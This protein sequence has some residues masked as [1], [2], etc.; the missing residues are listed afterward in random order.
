MR[1][2]APNEH[3]SGTGPGG[4]VFTDGVAELDPKRPEHRA[5][6]AYFKDRGYG[7]DGDEATQPEGAPVQP[8]SREVGGEHAVGERLRDAAV[9]PRESDFLVPTNAGEA[10]P[11]GPLVVAPGVHASETGPIHPGDVHVD[12]PQVQEAQET[13]L[14]EAVFVEGKDVTEATRAAAG[15]D[16]AHV[17]NQSAPKAD[18][19]EYAVSQGASRE[20]AESMT[21]ADLV[22]TYKES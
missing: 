13:A 5:A 10:D 21:K 8:D 12:D 17:P 1:I 16:E 19:V 7:I 14:A 18:W 2:T 3:Y 15:N 20:E 11:H 22:E 6:L 4:V 9:D